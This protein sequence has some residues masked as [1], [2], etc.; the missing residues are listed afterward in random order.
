M[1]I[2]FD[3]KLVL[4]ELAV[5]G[6]MEVDPTHLV[7]LVEGA[8]E[9]SEREVDGIV[10][11]AEVWMHRAELDTCFVAVTARKNDMATY[12]QSCLYL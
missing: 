6:P 1:E 9:V 5:E 2:F 4:F 11:N 3:V 12:N 7:G 8:P 10:H